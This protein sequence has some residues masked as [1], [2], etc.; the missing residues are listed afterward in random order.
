MNTS[1]AIKKEGVKISKTEYAVFVHYQVEQTVARLQ[2]F[3]QSEEAPI[4]SLDSS[5][6]FQTHV[7][8]WCHQ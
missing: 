7:I 3:A 1:R 6:Y 5:L 2:M 4:C 8:R